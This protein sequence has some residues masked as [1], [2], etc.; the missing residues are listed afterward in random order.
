MARIIFIDSRLEVQ[1]DQLK[2]EKPKHQRHSR[3]SFFNP[4]KPLP[5]LSELREIHLQEFGVVPAFL[6]DEPKRG[7]L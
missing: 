4:R 5:S 3:D 7:R 1:P 6:A 2:P